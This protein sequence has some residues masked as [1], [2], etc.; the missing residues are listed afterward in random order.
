MNMKVV[1]SALWVFGQSPTLSNEQGKYVLIL[2]KVIIST[3]LEGLSEKY[4]KL[5]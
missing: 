1:Y 2:F 5:Y 3:Q 4:M